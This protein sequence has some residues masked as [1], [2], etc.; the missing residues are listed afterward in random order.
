M[1]Q[2]TTKGWKKFLVILPALF[3]IFLFN[4]AAQSVS[5]GK[6][7]SKNSVVT[8]GS[9]ETSS[10]IN[11]SNVCYSNG[12]NCPASAPSS[13][14][15]NS[16]YDLWSYNQ[17]TSFYTWLTGFVYNYNQTYLGN[18]MDYTNLVLTN[19]SNYIQN[20]SYYSVITGTTTSGDVGGYFGYD[21][22]KIY[23]P[24]LYNFDIIRLPPLTRD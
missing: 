21:D 4:V 20:G 13:S 19:T 22:G 8:I 9:V 11:L 16:T 17:S 15:F 18:G 14:I 2:K 10:N 5:I 23:R 6:I 3:F 24:N 1:I 7:S 12:T